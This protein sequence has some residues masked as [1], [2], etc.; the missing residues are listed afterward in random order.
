MGGGC[1][2]SLSPSIYIVSIL[3][4]LTAFTPANQKN[5]IFHHD[6]GGGIEQPLRFAGQVACQ[7][8]NF[9][10]PDMSSGISSCPIRFGQ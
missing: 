5:V 8:Q 4:L 6:I 10:G 1:R 7:T 2:P 9:A 3:P